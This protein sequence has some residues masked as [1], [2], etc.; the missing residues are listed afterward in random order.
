MHYI[1]TEHG[2]VA[3]NISGK[4]YNQNILILILQGAQNSKKTSCFSRIFCLFTA[5]VVSAN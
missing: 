4:E 5:D 3:I 2:N 1:S